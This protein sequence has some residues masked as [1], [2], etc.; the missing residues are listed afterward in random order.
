MHL[1]FG[2]EIDINEDLAQSVVGVAKP[3]KRLSKAE[4]SEHRSVSLSGKG[5]VMVQVDLKLPPEH[6]LTE[7]APSRWQVWTGQCGLV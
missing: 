4:P 6:H 1:H 7:G 2:E 5:N 3:T